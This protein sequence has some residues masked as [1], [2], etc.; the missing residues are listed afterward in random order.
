MINIIFDQYQRYKNAEIIINSIRRGNETFN[1]LEVGANEH[2]N[3]EKF[4]PNDKVTYL[5]ICV[6]EKLRNDPQYILGD[7]TNMDFDDNCYD[8]V[9]ALDVYEHIPSE[10]RKNFIDELYRV[11][12]KVAIISAP[13]SKDEVVLAEER[14]NSYYKSIIGVNHQW[15]MEHIDNGLPS[16]DTLQQYMNQ[17]SIK[18]TYFSHGNL[19]TWEKLTN[20]QSLSQI[21]LGLEDYIAQINKYYNSLIFDKDYTENGYRNFFI[22]EK[23]REVNM[24]ME[25]K[26]DIINAQIDKL[27][28]NLY[29]LYR[30]RT[31]M[32]ITKTK[33]PLYGDNI[34]KIYY[35][36][37]NE[38][39]EDKSTYQSVNVDCEIHMLFKDFSREK[40]DFIRI[41]TTEKSG[42]FK[43]DN[44]VIKNDKGE[45]IEFTVKTNADNVNNSEYI[46]YRNDPQ[47]IL[48]FEPSIIKSL[49]FNILRICNYEE[50]SSCVKDI[51]NTI[52]ASIVNSTNDIKASQIQNMAYGTKVCKKIKNKIKSIK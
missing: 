15:L 2:K 32:G 33:L 21:D 6:P 23:T 14:C 9:I 39:S 8:I 52:N 38:C 27:L 37:N 20:A 17:K 13:F 44:V 3:L 41:D 36:N 43:F 5:D 24:T 51:V 29:R 35:G 40:I 11:C 28:E 34:V 16:L 30:I 10:K 45:S 12:S 4:L 1:I 47:I 48:S 7:A 49:E 19:D 31:S 22:M 46:F 26:I 25:N 50:N 18:Y 42:K